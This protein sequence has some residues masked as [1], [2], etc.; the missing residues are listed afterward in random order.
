M[1]SEAPPPERARGGT[2]KAAAAGGVLLAVLAK[3]KGLLIGL[4][5]LKLGKLLLTF[6][7]MFATIWVYA[8]SGGWAFGVGFVLLILI[9]ELGHAVAIRRAGLAAGYPVF[10]PFFGA[11]I[12]LKD[13]PRN[14]LVEAEIALAG[15]VAGTVAATTCA[16]LFFAS[17]DKLFLALAYSGFFLNLFN[18]T[19]LPPLDG[20]RVASM[21]SRKVWI[22]GLAVLGAMFFFTATPQLLL[23]GLMAVGHLFG[24]RRRPASYD[25]NDEITPAVRQRMAVRYFGLCAFLAVGAYFAHDL[26]N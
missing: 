18:L 9:H 5:F 13:Q 16:A 11:M 23:I 19:P 8:Q 10:I 24:G 2:A 7:S 22:V 14:A 21:F 1:A 26:L 6:V 3:A 20:G 4:K 15:P 12:A 17:H 25:V